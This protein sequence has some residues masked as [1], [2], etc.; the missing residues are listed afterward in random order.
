MSRS[1]GFTLVELMITIAIITV[2][3]GIAIPAFSHYIIEAEG[4]S[5][6][7]NSETSYRENRAEAIMAEHR[8]STGR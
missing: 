3:A 5:Q 8:E 7:A 1:K 4:T 6:K 2:L